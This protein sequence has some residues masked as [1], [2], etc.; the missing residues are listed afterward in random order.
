ML[1]R[2]QALELCTA[3]FG[4]ETPTFPKLGVNLKPFYSRPSTDHLVKT[5][6]YR[7]GHRILSRRLSNSGNDMSRDRGNKGGRADNKRRLALGGRAQIARNDRVV[8]FKGPTVDSDRPSAAEP[9]PQV[10]EQPPQDWTAPF[11]RLKGVA[12]KS[13]GGSEPVQVRG[14]VDGVQFYFRSRHG[15]WEVEIGAQDPWVY[16][17]R[18]FTPD[19]VAHLLAQAFAGWR[20]QRGRTGS[21]SEL[22]ACLNTCIDAQRERVRRIDDTTFTELIAHM[23]SI[24]TDPNFK[25][26]DFLCGWLF[27]HVLTL[28]DAT[29]AEVLAEA[30]GLDRVKETLS[31]LVNGVFDE[32]QFRRRSEV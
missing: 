29:P 20:C 2:C 21:P 22:R 1:F 32:Q 8:A 13:A 30:G 4:H 28:G 25:A 19:Q 17:G 14:A 16:K 26:V 24:V 15:E 7:R 10:R 27:E 23:R 31:R 5:M 9:P 11:R 12:I 3:N 6:M 18:V